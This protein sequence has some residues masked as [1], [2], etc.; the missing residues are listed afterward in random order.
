MAEGTQDVANILIVEDSAFH[1]LMLR[2]MLKDLQV[3]F[4]EAANGAD[5]LAHFKEHA[6]D[7]ILMDVEMPVMDGLTASRKIREELEQG[8]SRVPIIAMTGHLHSDKH[9]EILQAG[10]N[11]YIIKPFTREVLRNK[12]MTYLTASTPKEPASPES[13]PALYNLSNLK[14]FTRDNEGMLTQL[15]RYFITNTPLVLEEMD[16]AFT[17]SN[18]DEMARITHKFISEVSFLGIKLLENRISDLE[19]LAIKN[20]DP[21]QVEPVIQEI[22]LI[23]HQVIHQLNRDFPAKES[24]KT[25]I[26]LCEDDFMLSKTIEYKLKLDGYEVLTAENGK[27]G[28]SILTS[29]RIDLIVTDMLMPYMSGLEL[30]V[31][32]REKL[33]LSVPILVL[34][35]V[36]LEKTVIEAFELG[37]DDYIVKPFSPMELGARVKKILK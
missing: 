8:R 25:R 26:L 10:M 14:E 12:I 23:C 16:N 24:G 21:G 7:L 36:G 9:K 19:A 11:D 32:V 1:V 5:A 17:S 27:D 34:S 18:W 20:A 2:K 30:I 33:K 4:V 35:R 22:N 3:T 28:I 6:F 29:E 15:I 13:V 37:A 31:H